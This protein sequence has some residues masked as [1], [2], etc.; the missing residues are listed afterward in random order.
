VNAAKGNFDGPRQAQMAAAPTRALLIEAAHSTSAAHP[1]FPQFS[2]PTAVTI[3]FI[4]ALLRTS[5]PVK[6]PS[7]FK[8]DAPHALDDMLFHMPRAAP[9][10]RLVVRN[11]AALALPLPILGYA[12]LF[13]VWPWVY[14][15]FR[16]PPS[17]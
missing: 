16:V 15:G 2:L 6:V 9:P 5:Q 12:L 3:R 4:N 17:P 10:L 11:V 13:W 8:L 14:R 1:R 7:G